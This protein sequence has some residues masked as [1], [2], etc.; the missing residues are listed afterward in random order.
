[1]LPLVLQGQTPFTNRP[2]LVY[3]GDNPRFLVAGRGNGGTEHVFDDNILFDLIELGQFLGIALGNPW[4]DPGMALLKFGIPPVIEKQIVQETASSC[5]FG[6]P[7]KFFG[8]FIAG[9]GHIDGMFQPCRMVVVGNSA[10]FLHLG[11]RNQMTHIAHILFIFFVSCQILTS[12]DYY[13]I[14]YQDSLK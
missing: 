11:R 8:N 10:Q 2:I 7:A 14:V 12:S 6:I 3:A 9:V 13:S 5:R 1:M 4:V